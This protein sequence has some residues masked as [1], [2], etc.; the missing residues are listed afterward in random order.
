MNAEPILGFP[1]KKAAKEHFSGMLHTAELDADL[2]P[3]DMVLVYR[4]L[5]FHPAADEKIGPG[6][7]SI[8]V[9]S[10]SRGSRCFAAVHVTGHVERFSYKKCIDG[11]ET[12]LAKFTEA[13]REEVTEQAAAFLYAM[14]RRG[15]LVCALT[16][17]QLSG[18]AAADVDHTPPRVFAL[19]RSMY[20]EQ[21]P[22]L[23][24]HTT[25]GEGV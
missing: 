15:P 12:P 1:S 6:V 13:A 22:E 10:A 23:A 24:A 3:A 2:P 20:L 7:A 8:R 16:D 19:L 14:D 5:T 21:R 4:L 11:G 9:V 17:E 25:T 18:P